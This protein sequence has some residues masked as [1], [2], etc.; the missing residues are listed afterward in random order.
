MGQG[1]LK[2]P[3]LLSAELAALLSTQSMGAGLESVLKAQFVDPE[4]LGSS[5]GSISTNS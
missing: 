1:N 3:A 4:A 2:G 5:S